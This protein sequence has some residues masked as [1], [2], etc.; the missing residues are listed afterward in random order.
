MSTFNVS[1]VVICTDA[2]K[3]ALLGMGNAIGVDGGMSVPL[4]VTGSGLATHWMAHAWVRP[5]F[6]DI[7]TGRVVPQG[8]DPQAV[9]SMLCRC[10]V[11]AIPD[12]T[13]VYGHAETVRVG[14]GLQIIEDSQ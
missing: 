12:C 2:D 3:P 14:A 9:A 6:A 5:E 1:M 7:M 13:D 8:L 4:S 11:S 10:V